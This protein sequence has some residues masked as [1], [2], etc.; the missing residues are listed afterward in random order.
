MAVING[1]QQ[2]A[3]DSLREQMGV[4]NDVD[5]SLIEEKIAAVKKARTALMSYGGGM[6]G[7]FG[8][9]RAGCPA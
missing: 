7:G 3:K 1:I 9:G 5:W 2:R 8:G 6:M 4:T